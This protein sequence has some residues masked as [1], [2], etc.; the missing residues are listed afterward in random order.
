MNDLMTSQIYASAF[1]KTGDFLYILDTN[2]FLIDCN[3]NLLRFLG[4]SHIEDKTIGA[5]YEMMHK[6]GLWT[7]EQIEKFQQ[8]DIDVMMSGRSRVE[9]Q[10]M[11][12]NHGSILYFEISRLPL[13]DKSGNA[14]GLLVVLR[15]LTKQKQLNT[16]LRNI[17]SQLRYSNPLAVS[18]PEKGTQINALKILL[19][20][21]NLVAQKAEKTV[22]M[23]C[24]CLTD[25]VA[26]PRQAD[27]LFKPGKYDLV[28]MDLTL[29]EGDG[30]QLTASL[31]KRE[32]GSNFR[33]P[34]IA[35]TGH[36]PTVVGFNCEDAEMDGIL[37]K[38]LT[39]EQ[40]KQLIQRFIRHINVD[41]KGLKEFKQ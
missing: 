38:P 16:Q 27:E 23:S 32:Q 9:E 7:S 4:F 13:A 17:K 6:Q 11:I 40:A 41:V 10:A 19:I 8:Q 20:E 14:L 33:V 28:L 3:H 2:G 36:D 39:I 21:D 34:I 37:R 29:E 30:Y 35:L 22:L 12:N 26:T 25:V 31:R 5:I 24:K 1:S 15:D 18:S